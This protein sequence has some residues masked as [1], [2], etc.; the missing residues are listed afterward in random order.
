VT[1]AEFHDL[2]KEIEILKAPGVRDALHELLKGIKEDEAE[3][4][5]EI[6]QSH[7]SRN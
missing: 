5:E 1:D 3:V 7:E 4:V 2:S 6:R